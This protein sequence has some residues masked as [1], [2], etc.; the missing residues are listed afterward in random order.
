MLQTIQRKGIIFTSSVLF[1]QHRLAKKLITSLSMRVKLGYG[2]VNDPFENAPF[3]HNRRPSLVGISTYLGFRPD[4]TIFFFD[5]ICKAR[6][7]KSMFWCYL[8]FLWSFFFSSGRFLWRL[9]RPCATVSAR[10]RSLTK[11]P[12]TR[13][14]IQ[15]S[16]RKVFKKQTLQVGGGCDVKLC[17]Q[18]AKG[19]HGPMLL[20]TGQMKTCKKN[21]VKT[22]VAVAPACHEC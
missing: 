11:A 5:T 10:N 7:H 21:A 6:Q 13:Q 1:G 14:P 9:C 12:N 16:Q 19:N 18:Q 8:Q 2:V 20:K 22:P 17:R 4:T 3:F 15:I